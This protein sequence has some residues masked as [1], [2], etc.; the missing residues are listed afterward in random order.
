MLHHVNVTV[1][2]SEV[3]VG[4]CWSAGIVIDL[5]SQLLVTELTTNLWLRRMDRSGSKGMYKHVVPV[6]W[7]GM[8]WCTCDEEA[9]VMSKPARGVRHV[10][11]TLCH[12]LWQCAGIHSHGTNAALSAVR[13]PVVKAITKGISNGL[14]STLI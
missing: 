12:V 6:W 3:D 9:Y 10:Q 2:S 11:A 14:Y 1:C 7:L 5:D 8:F 13:V 4:W